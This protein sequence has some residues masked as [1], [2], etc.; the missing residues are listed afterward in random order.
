M[1]F[2]NKKEDVIDIE[3]T[4]YGKH[5]LSKGQFNPVYYEFYDDDIIYDGLY[6]GIEEIQGEIQT[7]IQ[8][9][10]KLKTQYTFESAEERMR[11]FKERIRKQPGTEPLLEKRKNF[12]FSSL[13]LANTSG[14]S[15]TASSLVISL[16]K[17]EIEKHE[18]LD[19]KGLPK[20]IKQIFLKPVKT[21]VQIRKIG[22]YETLKADISS[23]QKE[24]IIGEQRALVTKNDDYILLDIQEF[25]VDYRNDNF[26]VHLY[27][28]VEQEDGQIT[29]K[30]INFRKE[31]SNVIDGIL[32]ETNER[33]A[34]DVQQTKDFAEYYFSFLKDKE[35]PSNI[36]CKHLSKEQI[37][38]LNTVDG[39][40]I[41]CVDPQEDTIP[42]IE[43]I[44]EAN[45]EEC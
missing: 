26:E 23:L 37:A 44:S 34:Q 36:L 43:R 3:L 10:P 5:L 12:S 40:N 11:E 14:N 45:V 13:P 4:P 25:E 32:Y 29:E 38:K 21:E 19:S 24:V 39:F 30:Q 31:Y 22:K 9:T 18:L 17:S 33:P 28:L 15:K 7:R 8:E 42:A 16:L 20:T 27:E 2:F 6:A 1:T 41:E 35:I